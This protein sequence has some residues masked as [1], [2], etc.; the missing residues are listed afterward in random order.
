M[1]EYESWWKQH[2][3]ILVNTT[4]SSK[5]VQ[6]SK[7]TLRRNVYHVYFLIKFISINPGPLTSS[8]ACLVQNNNTS[9]CVTLL[10][11]NGSTAKGLTFFSYQHP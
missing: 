5:Q 7:Y 11:V 8:Q 3:T 9:P 4:K 1:L 2:G 10:D 6:K